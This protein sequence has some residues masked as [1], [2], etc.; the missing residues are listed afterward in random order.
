MKHY[1]EV[2]IPARI[3]KVTEKVTCDLCG[4]K[5]REGWEESIYDVNETEV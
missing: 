4:R 3:S 1:R 5:G 2:K